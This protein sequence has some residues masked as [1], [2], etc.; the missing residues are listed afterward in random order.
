MSD[1]VERDFIAC[2]RTQTGLAPAVEPIAQ[3]MQERVSVSAR[4]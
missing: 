2:L 3:G 1:V 4:R